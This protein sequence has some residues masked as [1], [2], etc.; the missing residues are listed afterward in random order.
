MTIPQNQAWDSR[1]GVMR[2]LITA[3]FSKPI[4][5][6]EVG[7]WFGIGSTNI[8]LHAL[9]DKSKLVLIDS[10]RPYASAADL[11]DDGWDYKAMDDLSS[12][13]F[14]SA[15]LNVKRFETQRNGKDVNVSL[16]RGSSKDFL[17][18]LSENSFDFIYVDGDHKYES[19]KSDLQ[20]AKRLVNKDFG[21]ICGDDLE[22]IP[23]T[24]L[25][26]LAQKN[27]DRD[28]LRHPHNFHPGVLLAVAEEFSAVNMVNGFWWV[29]CVDGNFS[30]NILMADTFI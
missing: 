11:K 7:V 25:Y 9:H 13:A 24:E 29:V 17:P 1:A 22:R 26:E 28:F 3:A 20:Q 19:V 12:D 23:T 16:I 8:W 27:K 21:I 6:L 15:Y 2:A 10:W 30:V 14:L 5:A 4:N 18:L